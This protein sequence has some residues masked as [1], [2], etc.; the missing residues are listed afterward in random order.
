MKKRGYAGSDVDEVCNDDSRNVK[1]LQEE[2]SNLAL[3]YFCIIMNCLHCAPGQ[4]HG[5]Y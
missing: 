3:I 1:E 5:R 4:E 2:V